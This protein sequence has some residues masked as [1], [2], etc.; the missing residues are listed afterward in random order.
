M[1][2]T[3]P[4]RREEGRSEQEAYPMP[5]YVSGELRAKIIDIICE[6]WPTPN[7]HLES[8]AIYERLMGEGIEVPDRDMS[9][10]LLTLAEDGRITLAVE[11]APTDESGVRKHGAMSIQGVSPELCAR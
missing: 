7:N 8:A 11:V 6:E 2:H 3:S 1:L 5:E 4:G 9:K 10:V